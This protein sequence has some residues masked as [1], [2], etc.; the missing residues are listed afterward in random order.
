MA[1]GAVGVDAG[2]HAAHGG[3]AWWPI[4]PAQRVAA[5]P[6]RGQ[7]RLGRV[8]R[9]FADRGQG[10]GAGQ[11]GG[12][13]DGQYRA[14]PVPSAASLSG[15]GDRGEVVEQAAALVRRQRDRGIQPLG[16]RGNAR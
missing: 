5:H 16:G 4:G 14:Q 6:E 15:V 10:S 11:H 9:P 7:H 12:D 1:R 2:Q 3:L 13:R 8:S